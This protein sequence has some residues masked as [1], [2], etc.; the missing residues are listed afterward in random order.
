[1]QDHIYLSVCHTLATYFEVNPAH[2]K[3]DQSL[4]RDWG[5]DPV[6]LNVIAV[7]IEEREDVEIRANDLENVET[8]GQLIALVRAIRRRNELA[9]EIT[10]V[11]DR[12]ASGV[13]RPKER[14]AQASRPATDVPECEMR[15]HGAP[16]RVIDDMLDGR[17]RGVLPFA[18]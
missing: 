3:P 17:R 18:P 5:V 16:K 9:E 8:V 2:V 14:G 10:L 4:R 13:H 15:A 1:M 7:R 6:E 11:R 12:R